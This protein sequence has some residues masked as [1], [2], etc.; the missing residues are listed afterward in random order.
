LGNLVKILQGF[1]A[2][3][4][5]A[6]QVT[7]PTLLAET[8]KAGTRIPASVRMV[9]VTVYRSKHGLL[10]AFLLPIPG[11]SAS[12]DLYNRA[13]SQHTG[14]TSPQRQAA[15]LKLSRDHKEIV[16]VGRPG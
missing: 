6:P 3:Y 14:R 7:I 2:P 16:S 15:A 5:L 12:P 4:E 13:C 1:T 9:F 11:L 10:L 8:L